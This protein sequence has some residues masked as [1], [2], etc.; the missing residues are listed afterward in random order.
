[1]KT[2]QKDRD[3]MSWQN[4]AFRFYL[5]AR[6]CF[7]RGLAPAAAFLSQQCIEQL[8]K[9]TLV[10]NDSSFNPR[11]DG[12]HDLRK[13]TQRIQEIVPGQ[14]RFTVPE[15]LCDGKYQSLSRYPDSKG[16]GFGVPAHL[17]ADVDRIFADLLEMV[18]FQHNSEL[19]HALNSEPS[20][21]QFWY[22]ELQTENMQ[23]DRLR[24][25][26]MKGHG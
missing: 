9:A 24:T 12:G 5:A 16:S 14:N 4:R 23:I 19:V 8:V 20:P 26:V 18:P 6:L 21:K 22:A 1:M 13:M 17:L 7:I 11:T 2:S 15:D 3:Y 25:H 10:W